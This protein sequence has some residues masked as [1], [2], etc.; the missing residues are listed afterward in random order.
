M[1]QIVYLIDQSGKF[2]TFLKIIG[3]KKIAI[4][5]WAKTGNQFLKKIVI[6]LILL[7]KSE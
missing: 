7:F 6:F 2:P 5:S 1:Y 4:C 3:I